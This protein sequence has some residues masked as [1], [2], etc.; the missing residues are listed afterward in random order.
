MGHRVLTQLVSDLDGT[1]AEATVHFGLDGDN[2]EIDL[3]AS[4]I[5]ELRAATATFVAHSRRVAGGQA[6]RDRPARKLPRRVRDHDPDKK[7]E[8]R[9]IR[10]W[11]MSQP[12]LK[13][14]PRGAIPV[15]ITSLYRE[16][17]RL[18]SRIAVEQQEAAS[19]V[20]AGTA[21]ERPKD[22]KNGHE[23]VKRRPRSVAVPF[24]S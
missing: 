22:L 24:S 13:V 20:I 14:H 19:T 4:Q 6:H 8:S 11:A 2:Y 21:T 7:D 15:S 3:S 12:D 16:Q 1:E 23:R 17:Q 18:L 9:K 5:E 10:Q